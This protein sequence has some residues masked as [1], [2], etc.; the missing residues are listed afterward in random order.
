LRDRRRARGRLG[1]VDSI[2]RYLLESWLA[3]ASM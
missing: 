1:N 3:E 2:D